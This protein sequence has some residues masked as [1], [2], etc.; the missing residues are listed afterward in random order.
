MAQ[1]PYSSVAGFRA[2]ASSARCSRGVQRDAKAEVQ[3]NADYSVAA[4]NTIGGH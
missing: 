2:C 1:R 3:V 4:M